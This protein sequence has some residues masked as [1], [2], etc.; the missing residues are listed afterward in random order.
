MSLVKIY[1]DDIGT[2]VCELNILSVM[3]KME[4]FNCIL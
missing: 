1:I 2:Y 3:G 4:V